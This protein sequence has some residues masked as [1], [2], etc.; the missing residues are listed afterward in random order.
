MALSLAHALPTFQMPPTHKMR[1]K[2][3]LWHGGITISFQVGGTHASTADFLHIVVF[4]QQ[5]AALLKGFLWRCFYASCL[6]DF[7]KCV[8]K[9]PRPD[10][11]FQ[12]MYFCGSPQ[13][14][15]IYSFQFPS[16]SF[17]FY[18]LQMEKK[19]KLTNRKWSRYL[20]SLHSPTW[21]WNVCS[22]WVWS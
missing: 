17:M 14:H 18:Y 22:E 12:C 1:R 8:R 10:A 11:S 16:E 4:M 7:T 19:S 5:R 15:G 6:G 2:T 3:F 21:F 9:Y 20:I 13:P